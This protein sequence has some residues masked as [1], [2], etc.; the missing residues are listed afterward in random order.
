MFPPRCKSTGYERKREERTGLVPDCNP[1]ASRRSTWMGKSGVPD[2]PDRRLWYSRRCAMGRRLSRRLPKKDR[3]G[4][5]TG[6]R[7]QDKEFDT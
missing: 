2:G 5:V 4:H 6:I 7:E 3:P 1:F